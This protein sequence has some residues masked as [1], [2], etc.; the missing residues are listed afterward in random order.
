MACVRRISALLVSLSLWMTPVWGAVKVPLGTVVFADRAHLGGSGNMVSVGA[1]VFGGDKLITEQT[2][3]VQVRAGA[4]RLILSGSSIAT[5]SQDNAAA[6][7]RLSS[8]T[9]VFSTA[10]SNAFALYI[11][12]AVIRPLSN[13]PTIGQVTVLDPKQLIVRSTRGSLTITVLDDTRVIPEGAAYRVVLDPDAAAAAE[14]GPQEPQGVGT[15]GYGRR[16]VKAGRS[17]FIWFAIGIT[18]A[19]TF[20]AL[21]EALESPD[22]PAR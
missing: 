14:A 22:R 19:V 7:A 2:G 21:S 13:E 1:T 3:S 18:A 15:R 8:G 6:S 4:A 10:N 5:L 11:A 12:T 17:R 9:A 20:I 16:P